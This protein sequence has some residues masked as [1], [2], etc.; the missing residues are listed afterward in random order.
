MIG[1]CSK[2]YVV[3]NSIETKPENRVKFSSNGVNKHRVVDPFN[4][5]RVVLQTGN[6]ATT[7]N[8]GFRPKDN[9]VFT[10]TQEKIG[11]NYAYVKRKVLA[12]GIHT[13]PLDITLCPVTEEEVGESLN[14]EA[15]SVVINF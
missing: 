12:D 1:L 15:D 11:W 9:T 8:L 14:E 2:S 10:Y 4:T 5:F 13:G 7:V 3:A 6:A